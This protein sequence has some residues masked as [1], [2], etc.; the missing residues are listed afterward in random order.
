MLTLK[1]L[2]RHGKAIIVYNQDGFFNSLFQMMDEC[3]EK[4]FY[5]PCNKRDL[6]GD[7]R[8]R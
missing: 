5:E 7:D 4:G 3:V 8:Y 1:Q 2:G 6:S